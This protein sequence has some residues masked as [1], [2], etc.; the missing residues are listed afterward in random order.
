MPLDVR[1][2]SDAELDELIEYLERRHVVQKQEPYH[3]CVDRRC[4]RLRTCASGGGRC[5][6]MNVPRM[7]KRDRKRN[8]ASQA[9]SAA[10]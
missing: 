2:L 6:C 8:R 4:R 3:R 10:A 7:G 1:A 5:V 9:R